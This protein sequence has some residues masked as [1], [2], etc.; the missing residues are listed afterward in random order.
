MISLSGNGMAEA[1][2]PEAL[3]R[4]MALIMDRLDVRSSGALAVRLGRTIDRAYGERTVRNWVNGESGPEC[5]SLMA[6]L[7]AADLLMPEAVA[8]WKGPNE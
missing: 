3:Q 7:S 1:S 4:L 5:S 8:A 6:M 2:D